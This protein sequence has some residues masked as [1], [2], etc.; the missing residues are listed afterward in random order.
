MTETVDEDYCASLVRQEDRDRF[1]ATLFA[2]AESRP[3][4][5]ALYAFNVEVERIPLLVRDPFA[6]E[7][8]LQWWHDVIAGPAREQAAGSPVAAAL[9]HTLRRYDLSERMLL[10]LL[11]AHRA[12]LYDDRIDTLADLDAHAARTVGA[13]YLLAAQ[14]L[15]DEH[16]LL[17][18]LARHAGIAHFIAHALETLPRTASGHAF[19]VPQDILHRHGLSRETFGPDFSESRSRAVIN[20]LTDHVHDQLSAL[21]PLLARAPA[22]VEPAFLPLALVRPLIV[23]IDRGEL[24]DALPR[25]RRQ[26]ILWRASR[27]LMRVL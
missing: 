27:D 7:V 26:W 12:R 20:A 8:R 21:R 3:P 2:P 14:I 9:I 15:G 22:A 16:D 19:F 10:D 11:D 24:G 13:I 18:V 25:W 4:L 5:M 6:G 1:I 23:R 17:A